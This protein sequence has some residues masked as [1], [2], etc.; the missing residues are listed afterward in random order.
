MKVGPIDLKNVV[1]CDDVRVEKSN[2][3]ILIGVYS[4]NIVVS[5]TPAQLGVSLYGEALFSKPGEHRLSIRISVNDTRLGE[6]G[7]GYAI[8]DTSEALG[9]HTP[10]FSIDIQGPSTLRIEAS[11][12]HEN[13]KTII[14]K[15]ILVGEVPGSLLVATQSPA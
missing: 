12:D 7:I 15:R 10:Q 6:L 4:A 9:F 13:W 14:D 2:K 11:A 8:T 5:Q 1:L 3:F